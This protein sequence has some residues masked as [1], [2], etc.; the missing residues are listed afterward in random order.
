M[1]VRKAS[2]EYQPFDR[3]KFE[4]SLRNSGVSETTTLRMSKQASQMEGVLKST[5]TIYD[6]ARRELAKSD[7][8]SAMRY[9]L[10]RALIEL[11]PTGYPFERYVARLLERQGYDCQVGVY[12][13]G[14]CVSHEVDV[15]ATRKGEVNVFECKF[16]NR[17]GYKTGVKTA[18]YVKARFDDIEKGYHTDDNPDR[19]APKKK[20][21]QS[22]LVTNTKHTT[23]AVKY[24]E[25]S[26][27]KLVSWS[28]PAGNSLLEWIE[29]TD[30][31]PITVLFHLDKSMKSKLLRLNTVTLEDLL[32]FTAWNSCSRAEQRV[33][34]KLKDQARLLLP[35]A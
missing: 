22:W 32:S 33:I 11:G 12:V 29:K 8:P 5:D 24:A 26:G 13:R 2:G 35:N 15:L 4:T 10:R 19:Q 16:H 6:F 28:Y 25:C 30:Q 27:V 7:Q 14:F 1:K 23:E 9:S 17:K 31:Y 34:A 18:L 21:H 20:I 3:E